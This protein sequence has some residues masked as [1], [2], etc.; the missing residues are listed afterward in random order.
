M[1][2]FSMNELTRSDTAIKHN[3]AN[4]P[5][6]E[7]KKNLIRLVE[8]ILD[9]LRQAYGKPIKVNSGFRSVA[10]NIL[11]GGSKTSDHMTGC[12]ADITAG[13]VSENKKLF[14]LIQDLKL[15]FTQLIDEKGMKWVH[16][17]YNPSKPKQGQIL[18]IK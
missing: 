14:K 16:V 8:V 4:V 6:E 15:P 2:F 5:N 11:V 1:R 13:S 10:V 3:I 18:K 12:A 17:S 7:Q 9:P